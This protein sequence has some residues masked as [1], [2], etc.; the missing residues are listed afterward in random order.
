MRSR[1]PLTVWGFMHS[2]N[3]SALSAA[4]S[5]VSKFGMVL[6]LDQFPST[7][8][9]SESRKEVLDLIIQLI[10][11]LESLGAGTSLASARAL[12]R[13][14]ERGDV[15]TAEAVG[16]PHLGG[17]WV[18]FKG[19]SKEEVIN[20]VDEL[21]SR[22]R[23]ELMSK[24]MLVIDSDK[25]AFYNISGSSLWSV[26]KDRFPSALY[27]LDEAGKLFALGRCTSCVFHLMRV[28]EIGVRALSRHLKIPDPIKSGDRNWGALLKKLERIL[29]PCLTGNLKMN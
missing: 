12:K 3:V 8:I 1:N 15:A 18:C 20:H 26:V 16:A 17:A 13:W 22:L 10:G 24:L 28:S 5:S 7:C 29:I 23:D 19:K 6:K 25:T 2:L 4:I 21:T 14:V 27:D 9:E 11:E